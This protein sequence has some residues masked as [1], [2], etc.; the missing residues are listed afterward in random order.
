[1]HFLRSPRYCSSLLLVLLL[2][3][4]APANAIDYRVHYS[5][6]QTPGKPVPTKVVNGD[7][8]YRAWIAQVRR[9]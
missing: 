3:V 5:L 6:L 2:L 1:M 7:R 9:D 4:A 8:Q